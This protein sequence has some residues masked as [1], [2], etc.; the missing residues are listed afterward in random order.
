MD[1]TFFCCSTS[2][3]GSTVLSSWA[4]SLKPH[5]YSRRRGP[6]AP[7]ATWTLTRCSSFQPFLRGRALSGNYPTFRPQ[8]CRYILHPCSPVDVLKRFKADSEEASHPPTSD[9]RA[10]TV[11]DEEDDRPL[12]A[13]VDS[14]L[15]GEQDDDDEDGRFFG[16]GLNEEQT[17]RLRWD[18]KR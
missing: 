8:V 15:Q 11:E 5:T 1:G 7:P 12:H 4:P 10:A 2:T 3:L 17:V 14:D 18:Y 16:G 6:S 13:P 9:R